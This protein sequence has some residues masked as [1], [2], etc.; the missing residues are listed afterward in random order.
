[1]P[2]QSIENRKEFDVRYQTSLALL[3]R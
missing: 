1:L 2:L 3:W